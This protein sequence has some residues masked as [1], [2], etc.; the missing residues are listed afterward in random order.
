MFESLTSPAPGL[1]D[2]RTF[3]ASR[4]CHAHYL[5][6]RSDDDTLGLPEEPALAGLSL[7]VAGRYQAPGAEEGD[8]VPFEIA[9]TSPSARCSVSRP[10][11]WRKVLMS[12]CARPS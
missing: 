9:A 2:A 8:E 3:T 7:W 4:F 5:V 12:P 10:A 1:L 6:A 11:T